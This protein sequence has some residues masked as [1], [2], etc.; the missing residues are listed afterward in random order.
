[1]RNSIYYAAAVAPL[2]FLVAYFFDTTDW[3][4]WAL[5]AAFWWVRVIEYAAKQGGKDG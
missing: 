5:I 4:M 3:E 1:M 2:A